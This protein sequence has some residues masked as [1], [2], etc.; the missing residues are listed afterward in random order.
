MVLEDDAFVIRQRFGS[1]L[2]FSEQLFSILSHIFEELT[3]IFSWIWSFKKIMTQSYNKKKEKRQ[4][5]LP[6]FSKYVFWLREERIFKIPSLYL[7]CL[8][9]P[10]LQFSLMKLK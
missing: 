6:T 3:W 1:K 10:K 8:C 5:Y 2:S 7:F 9:P 4:N